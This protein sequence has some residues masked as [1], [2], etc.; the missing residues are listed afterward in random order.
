MDPQTVGLVVRALQTTA[1]A[2]VLLAVWTYV[3]KLQLNAQLRKLPSLTPEGTTKAR[4]K[5]MA[6]ARKLYQDG[7]HKFRDSAYTLINENGNANVIVPPQFLPELRQLPDDVL[8]FPEAL[9]EDLEIKYTHLSIENPTAAGLIKKKLTPA[10]PRLNPS[11]CQDVDRA[12]KTYMPPCDDW[13]EVNINEKLLR[14]VAKVS[15][16]IFVGPELA[17][18]SDYLDAACFYTVDLMNAVTAMKKIRPWLKPFLASRTPEIIALRAREKHT[19]RVLIPIVEQRIAA[20]ANDPNW[21]EPDDF[22]QWMLD[23]REGTESIQE[24][25]KTQLSL[26]F[27]AIHTTTMT[28]TNTMY[29]LAAMPEY[30]EPLREEIRNVMLDEGGVITSRALQRMEKLDSYMKE[31]LRFTGPTMTSFTRRARKGITLSNGQ[32]IPAGVI[33]EV[34]SAAIYQDNAFYPS[35]DSFDGFRA[36]KA[37][38]TGKAADI[39]RNQF[40]TSNEENLTFGYGRHACPG[41]FFAAN[42]IKMM[43][44]RLILDYDIKMPNG[45]KERYP[46]IEIGKMSIPDPTKTLAFKRVVV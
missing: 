5:F 24:L 6:S 2:A 14:I 3:P 7:Y 40:V 18:D 27:A 46:Q 42:E 34:P 10:L 28:V 11:I 44:T 35:S 41:R 25:A 33:I 45:E 17:S 15:G 37:R 38:S 1:I 12:V 26:I 21:Q 19:E 32:Y 9:T 31:V 20:K 29:T 36:Y 16:T 4:D 30:L 23:M 43:I 39:A 22:L 13:T 8:S